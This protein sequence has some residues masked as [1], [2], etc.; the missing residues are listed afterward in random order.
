MEV[1]DQLANCWLLKKGCALFN[2]CFL[3]GT[4]GLLIMCNFKARWENQIVTQIRKLEACEVMY[5]FA[6]SSWKEELYG[7]SPMQFWLWIEDSKSNFIFTHQCFRLTKRVVGGLSSYVLSSLNIWVDIGQACSTTL[8]LLS[9]L[10]SQVEFSHIF[11]NSFFIPLACAECNDSLLFSGASSIPLCYVIFP[12]TLLH[13]LFFHPP[14]LHL[15]IYFLVYLSILFPNSY[16][17]LSW[18]FYFL[19]FSVHAQINIIYLTL[20]SLIVGFL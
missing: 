14:S 12:A 18:E 1:I 2:T 4:L 15:A 7:V 17:I 8:F 11:I 9:V 20:L 16:I 19:P 3:S 10:Y 5:T 6:F 13:W